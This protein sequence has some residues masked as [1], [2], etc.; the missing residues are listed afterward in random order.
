MSAGLPGVGLSGV[1]FIIS[2]LVMVPLEIARTVR[3]Q[4][5][6]ARW[7][8]VLRHLAM[9]LA[10]IVCVELTYAGVRLAVAAL[11]AAT[12]HVSRFGAAGAAQASVPKPAF[13]MLPVAPVAVTL[14]VVALLLV[15]AK[16]AHLLSRWRQARA[17]AIMRS[18]S[19]TCSL[20]STPM[21]QRASGSPAQ[22]EAA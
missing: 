4:S 10:M 3:G 22:S 18:C 20:P 16:S 9:A 11:H 13:H 7:A 17:L 21:P 8:T 15:A 14:A 12:R 1:F 2:A 5:S 19:A 6:L